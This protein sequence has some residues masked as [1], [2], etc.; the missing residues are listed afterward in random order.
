[1][2]ICNKKSNFLG[3]DF[4]LGGWNDLSVEY[5]IPIIIDDNWFKLILQILASRNFW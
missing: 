4:H 3:Y 2:E 5:P 1:M